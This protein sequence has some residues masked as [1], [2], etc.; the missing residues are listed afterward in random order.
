MVSRLM[1]LQVCSYV[2]GSSAEF[3]L[4]LFRTVHYLGPHYF[5]DTK[6]GELPKGEAMLFETTTVLRI[7]PLASTIDDSAG[8]VM[9]SGTTSVVRNAFTEAF[10][11]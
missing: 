5:V 10:R 6:A 1:L 8:A 2:D 9:I 11:R 3:S 7:L 4:R